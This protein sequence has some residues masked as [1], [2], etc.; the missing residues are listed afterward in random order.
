MMPPKIISFS[1]TRGAPVAQHIQQRCLD[2]IVEC[3]SLVKTSLA[4]PTVSFDLRGTTAGEAYGPKNHIRLNGQLLNENIDEFIEQ[5]VGHE[6][7]HL[8]ARNLHGPGIRSHGPEWKGVMIKLGLDPA[9][10]HTYETT[11]ARV[12]KPKVQAKTARSWRTTKPVVLIQPT[13]TPVLPPKAIFGVPADMV[14]EIRIPGGVAAS[15]VMWSYANKLS[16]KKGMPLPEMLQHSQA[17][18]TQWIGMAKQRQ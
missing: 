8:A 7:A 2:R 5:T 16:A 1:R 12:V 10:C 6:W 9:R 17:M 3:Q 14:I 4:S 11:K 13:G 15:P 18:L